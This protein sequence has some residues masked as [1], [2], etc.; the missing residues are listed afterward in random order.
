MRAGLETMRYVRREEG[1][2]CFRIYGNQTASKS[3]KSQVQHLHRGVQEIISSSLV[4]SNLA[5]RVECSS[6]NSLVLTLYST[7]CKVLKLLPTG[8]NLASKATYAQ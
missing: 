2:V 6:M 1:F 4:V 5:S 8:F 7:A 3:G